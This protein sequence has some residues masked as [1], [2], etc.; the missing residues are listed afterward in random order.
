MFRPLT[1]DECDEQLDKVR[2]RYLAAER[3]HEF[4]EAFDL[5]AELQW[6]LD[7]RI[8]M[9]LPRTSPENGGSSC[10]GSPSPP[11]APSPS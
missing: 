8:R 6:L 2:E 9:P 1:I 5:W 7:M 11:S 10:T 4:N 3:H